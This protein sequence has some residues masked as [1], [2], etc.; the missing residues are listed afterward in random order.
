MIRRSDV[1]NARTAANATSQ[2]RHKPLPARRRPTGTCP[3]TDG[4][5]NPVE[6]VAWRR[7]DDSSA[8]RVQQAGRCDGTRHR[9]A[10]G[11]C[12][13]SGAQKTQT[14]PPDAT[15]TQGF[16][17]DVVHRVISVQRSSR[18]APIAASGHSDPAIRSRALYGS[19]H[20]RFQAEPGW[21]RADAA[22]LWKERFTRRDARHVD[23]T[24]PR[25]EIS[26]RLRSACLP[27]SGKADSFQVSPVP[28][29]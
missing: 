25:R 8:R 3:P 15:V 19:K 7:Q 24:I 20:V 11:T 18:L 1:L 6:Q 23:R 13:T 9:F 22:H 27:L 29:F 28:G 17:S 5:A 16:G 14:A 4:R 12:W 21:R 10:V 2:W 26:L